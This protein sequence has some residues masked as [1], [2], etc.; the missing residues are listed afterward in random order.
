MKKRYT[1]E[2]IE[3]CL[4]LLFLGVWICW[5]VFLIAINIPRVG[6]LPFINIGGWFLN[7]FISYLVWCFGTYLLVIVYALLYRLFSK[8]IEINNGQLENHA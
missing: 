6:G 2:G 5:T 8:E 7:I 4:F 3:G 1:D